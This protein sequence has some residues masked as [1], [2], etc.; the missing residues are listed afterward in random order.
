MKPDRIISGTQLERKNNKVILHENQF[1]IIK[2]HSTIRNT[3]N[4]FQHD[5]L[6]FS[7]E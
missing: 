4:Q 1:M 6:M 7:S 2:A 5:Y 3:H